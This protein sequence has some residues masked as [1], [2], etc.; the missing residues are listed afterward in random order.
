[1]RPNAV[2]KLLRAG[3]PA[4]GTWLTLGNIPSARFLA[5]SGFDWLT[6]DI[7]HSAVDIQTAST[8]LGAIADAGVVAL[9]RVPSNSHE[10]IKRVLDNGG[11]GVV[12]PMVN[13]V[14][15]A[16]EA[17]SACLYPPKGT[18]SVGG[19]LHALSWDTT[20]AEYFAKV[21]SEVLIVLQCEHID[22]VRKFEEIYSEPR[23]DCVFVGP[24]DLAASLRKADGTSATTDE[25]ERTLET[26]LKVCKKLGVAPGIH[27][28]TAEDA[29]KRIQQ[30]WQFVAIGS[31]QRFVSEGA[32]RVMATLKADAASSGG[33]ATT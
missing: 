26:I 24:S 5:R 33:T 9:A 27:T 18:R 23:I 1:M 29:K 13:S 16:R 14:E 19:S 3:K 12:V 22:A 15:E 25:F 32:A 7:E 30:G 31:D 10:A 28:F 20:S 2:K 8:M 17:V 4:V 6:V 11:H 21:D